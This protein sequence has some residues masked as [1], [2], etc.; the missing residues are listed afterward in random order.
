MAS[1]NSFLKNR[2]SLLVE[3]TDSCLIPG[4]GVDV[5]TSDVNSTSSVLPPSISYYEISSFQGRGNSE[6]NNDTELAR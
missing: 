2:F 1:Y 6:K 4:V 5:W 3:A